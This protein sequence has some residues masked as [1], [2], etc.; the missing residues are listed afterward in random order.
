MRSVFEGFLVEEAE[1]I[2]RRELAPQ[3]AYQP[4][5]EVRVQGDESI[6]TLVMTS[7]PARGANEST[8]RLE[9]I[10][11]RLGRSFSSKRR[12][13]HALQALTDP[14]EY[15]RTLLAAPAPGDMR[16]RR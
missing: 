13:Q 9:A 4:S 15:E 14:R 12:S 11:E 7:P 8:S 10:D 3:G 16:R 1:E 6:R 2:V 5:V